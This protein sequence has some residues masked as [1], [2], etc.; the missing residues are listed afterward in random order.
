MLRDGGT[1]DRQLLSELAHGEWARGEPL[2]D[3]PPRWIAESL[4]RLFVGKCARTVSL[5]L[6]MPVCQADC[7]P[8]LL[9]DSAGLG[10][11]CKVRQLFAH[12][13]IEYER[14]EVSV[15]DRS[16][17]QELLGELNPGA[18]RA[19]AGAR[20]RPLARRVERDH[21][22]LRRG[23]A[24]PARGPLRARPGA[25]VAVL[26]A[27]QPRA[28]HRGRA[29]LGDR[30]D[31][32]VRGRPGGQARGGTAA[33]RAMERASRRAASSW[34]ASATRSPT[35]RCTPTRTWRRR[36]ASSSSPIRRSA[37]GSSAWRPSRATSR[38]PTDRRA[39]RATEAQPARSAERPRRV[40]SGP[41]W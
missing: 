8:M 27:V 35:S 14:R 11:C 4:E 12:L 37:P 21:V 7:A 38:S 28:V 26:R 36:A 34:S 1:A 39:T 24:V 19:H 15:I 23:H 32:A 16:G 17:R 33:L 5:D 10:N 41:C 18:A 29:L 30:R 13:G 25:P 9:Y 6:R 22:L 3:L 40:P 20:R 31:H 2:E